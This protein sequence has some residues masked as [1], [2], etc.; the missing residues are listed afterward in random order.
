MYASN[1]HKPGVGMVIFEGRTDALADLNVPLKPPTK[2][3]VLRYSREAIEDDYWGNIVSTIELT[4]E[5]SEE[6]VLGIE[7]FSHLEVIFYF[8]QVKS[9][10]GT[11]R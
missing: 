6:S 11:Q 7:D 8:N 9:E 5:F 1:L 2:K 4:S 10:A 3:T